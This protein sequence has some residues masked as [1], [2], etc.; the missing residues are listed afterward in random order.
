MSL[1]NRFIVIVAVA[2]SAFSFF[3]S[4]SMGQGPSSRPTI[5][6]GTIRMF[7]K[8]SDSY[9]YVKTKIVLPDLFR[10]EAPFVERNVRFDY[11]AIHHLQEPFANEDQLFTEVSYS[12]TERLG[13]VFSAPVHIRDN[14]GAPDA[15]GVGDVE[16]GVR[17]VWM[18]YEDR[19]PIQFAF[20]FNVE[21]PTGD[22]DR[23]LGEGHAVL[24]PEILFLYKIT[25]PTFVQ[26]QLSVG[27]PTAGAGR[28]TEFGYNLAIG[29]VFVDIDHGDYFKFPTAVLEL[30]GEAGLGGMEAGESVVDLTA[31]LRWAMGSKMFAGVGMSFPV[32]KDRHFEH[33]FIF[34]LIY[35]YGPAD[36]QGVD[37]TSSRVYF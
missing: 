1:R 29:H 7:N 4:P 32:T 5:S 18:S 8:R 25:E 21:A 9:S 26:G 35:R 27:V 22:E 10:T 6:G 2:T 17:Y 36:E 16:V 13:V 30:N 15:S 24:E 11:L 3:A 12:F 23:E 34:S 28:T 33:Q 20:G 19:D 14:F 31:G 37:N